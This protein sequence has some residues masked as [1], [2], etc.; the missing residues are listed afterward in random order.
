MSIH[1][2]LDTSNVV[3]QVTASKTQIKQTQT[4][5]QTTTDQARTSR[6]DLA[7]HAMQLTCHAATQHTSA[8]PIGI[9]LSR[10]SQSRHRISS[11]S[12]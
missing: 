7:C 6:Y 1:I 12:L 8:S 5:Q 4:L 11:D 3:K 9:A 10:T 2:R